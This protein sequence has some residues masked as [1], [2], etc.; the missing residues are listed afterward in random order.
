MQTLDV[1][2]LIEVTGDSFPIAG[3]MLVDQL[4]EL[5]ILLLRPPPFFQGRTLQLR[6]RVVDHRYFL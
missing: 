1:G 6:V 2:A 3:A 5:F 4:F